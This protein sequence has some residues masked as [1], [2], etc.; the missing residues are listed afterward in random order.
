MSTLPPICMGEPFNCVTFCVQSKINQNWYPNVLWARSLF[1]PDQAAC[2]FLCRILFQV[3]DGKPAQICQKDIPVPS[4]RNSAIWKI[5]KN[6]FLRIRNECPPGKH[7]TVHPANILKDASRVSWLVS[8]FALAERGN[9]LIGPLSSFQ[10]QSGT[11]GILNETCEDVGWQKQ[12]YCPI[13]PKDPRVGLCTQLRSTKTP[14]KISKARRARPAKQATPT[15]TPIKTP[16][17]PSCASQNL[18]VQ[19]INVSSCSLEI[20]N[21]FFLVLLAK[22]KFKRVI[23]NCASSSLFS[24]H[25]PLSKLKTIQY[26]YL[27]W[28]S[29][30]HQVNFSQR[31]WVISRM[32]QNPSIVLDV[33]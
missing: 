12:H 21:V 23:A 24:L 19:V 22:V 29:C 1:L 13:D 10:M 27:C 17:M 31:A 15:I 11:G 14:R 33:R 9:H 16:L 28:Y 25:L 5:M 32:K 20:H 18:L 8:W 7:V 3:V 4:V 2:C 30:G 26:R 6:Q